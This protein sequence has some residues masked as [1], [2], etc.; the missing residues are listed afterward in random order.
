MLTLVML[1]VVTVIVS[2]QDA[3]TAAPE[4]T[5]ADGAATTS[6]KP[7]EW[8]SKFALPAPNNSSGPMPPMPGGGSGNTTSGPPVPKMP[9]GAPMG[10]GMGGFGR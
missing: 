1:T 3:T 8:K 10:G 6:H 9:A 4:A 7:G 2:G 5:T